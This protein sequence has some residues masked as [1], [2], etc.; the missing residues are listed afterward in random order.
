MNPV[1]ILM[2]V[3]QKNVPWEREDWA[4]TKAEGEQWFLNIRT[5]NDVPESERG[6]LYKFRKFSDNWYA[7]AAYAVAGIWLD[8]WVKSLFIRLKQEALDTD[9]E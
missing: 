9:D 2:D 4:K 3:L 7:K 5:D 1:T 6:L 8:Y